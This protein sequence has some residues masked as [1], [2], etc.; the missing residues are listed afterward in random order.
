MNWIA[1][2][3]DGEDGYSYSSTRS[4][5]LSYSDD[6]DEDADEEDSGGAPDEDASDEDQDDSD[7]RRPFPDPRL[8]K[9]Q[10]YLRHSSD[11]KDDVSPPT[12]VE[13]AN[14]PPRMLPRLDPHLAIS[15]ITAV[16]SAYSTPLDSPLVSPSL[17][18]HKT[19]VMPVASN[20]PSPTYE[21][22][23]PEDHYTSLPNSGVERPYIPHSAYAS[24]A[25]HSESESDY[26]GRNRHPRLLWRSTFDEESLR[27]LD[28][29][30]QRV[31]GGPLP[32]LE[33]DEE[34]KV[35]LSASGVDREREHAGQGVEEVKEKFCARFP[36]L[37]SLSPSPSLS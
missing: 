35:V 18:P 4:S 37:W 9:Q 1:Y 26:R 21:H 3:S 12:H 11:D 32:R 2:R 28:A 19:S 14:P 5:E 13:H 36:F 15:H 16:R 31:R 17:V 7:E 25:S 20:L 33:I 8:A 29:H 6:Y 30:H 27:V 23:H 34:G 22:S 10:K 24:E